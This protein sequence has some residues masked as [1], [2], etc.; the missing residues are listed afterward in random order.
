[1]DVEALQRRV[2]SSRDGWVVREGDIVTHYVTNKAFRVDCVHPFWGD[3]WDVG[4]NEIDVTPLYESDEDVEHDEDAERDEDAE[5]DA[6]AVP[7]TT[8]EVFFSH[9]HDNPDPERAS[10]CECCFVHFDDAFVQWTFHDGAPS[11]FLCGYLVPRGG[12]LEFQHSRCKRC[13]A[14]YPHGRLLW[15]F[16]R[17]AVRRRTIAM[18]WNSLAHT[19]KYV[20]RVTAEAAADVGGCFRA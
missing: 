10:F 13:A 9:D 2:A 1:M 16:V 14:R 18:Y 12:G 8:E 5:S 15:D 4:S 7:S 3:A 19:P 20:N 11:R 17:R 6:D